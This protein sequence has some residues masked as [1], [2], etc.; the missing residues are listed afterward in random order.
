MLLKNSLTIQQ[1]K[2]ILN[3][4]QIPIETRSTKIDLM[5]KLDKLIELIGKDPKSDFSELLVSNERSPG[6]GKKKP[7][8]NF[9]TIERNNEAIRPTI[10][11]NPPEQFLD[12]S[13]KQTTDWEHWLQK[14]QIFLLSAGYSNSAED[15]K[16]GLLLNYLGDDAQ[17]VFLDENCISTPYKEAIIFFKKRYGSSDSVFIT[18]MKLRRLEQYE[19][20]SLDEFASRIKNVAK[21]CNFDK[22]EE[23]LAT[24]QF[25]IGLRDARLRRKLIEEHETN[26]ERAIN[27]GKSI[28]GVDS[29]ISELTNSK[30]KGWEIHSRKVQTNAAEMS[31]SYRFGRQ[32]K[33]IQS[34][35]RPYDCRRCGRKHERYLECPALKNVCYTCNKPGHYSRFCRSNSSTNTSFHRN[36]PSQTNE[37]KQSKKQIN[38]IQ[39]QNPEFIY[40]TVL[41]ENTPISMLCDTGASTSLICN[42]DLQR[43]PS[44]LYV[45]H[46][47][48]I[49]TA[50]DGRQL[51][52]LGYI[53]VLIQLKGTVLR[54]KLI[55]TEKGSS[56]LGI[57]LLREFGFLDTFEGKGDQKFPK[58]RKLKIEEQ[59][60]QLVKN[61]T[62]FR[63]KVRHV[64][65]VY[66]KEFEKEIR[67][68]VEDGTL[69]EAESSNW[70][71]P[72]VITKKK[73]RINS[74][75]W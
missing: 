48:T 8:S 2:V 49:L 53:D 67:R 62:P 24:Q 36:T 26:L 27:C 22:L 52:T 61:A 71:S 18:R 14:F 31:N 29:E 68:M 55:V 7:N 42:E 11:L 59:E 33:N 17:K 37:F 34:Q 65:F 45:Y 28:L 20:E 40:K 10:L 43:L 23:E 35:I 58:N 72:V 32:E 9:T 6:I 57:D 16:L 4:F 3:T 25:I 38:R 66:R 75:L 51:A 70:S 46:M 50:F 60:L 15:I 74:D 56:I 1:I 41:I 47:D 30:N 73:I 63:Q 21:N 64:A 19:N 39:H 12:H 5:K 44:S 69:I 54:K 13:G